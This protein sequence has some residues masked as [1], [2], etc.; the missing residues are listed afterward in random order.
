MIWRT[1]PLWICLMCNARTPES[2][3]LRSVSP[4][5]PTD[6]ICGCPNC[7]GVNTLERGCDAEECKERS[8]CGA[9]HGDAGY[10]STC[11]KHL[12]AK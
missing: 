10:K 1:E 8:S 6:M 7:N 3:V 9:P 11:Y 5:D 2:R 12:D 4:F